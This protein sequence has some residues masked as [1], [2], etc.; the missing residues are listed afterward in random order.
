[1]GHGTVRNFSLC[2]STTW[3]SGRRRSGRG[4]GERR[5]SVRRGAKSRRARGA[6]ELGSRRRPCITQCERCAL[7]P[8]VR[9]DGINAP[10]RRVANASDRNERPIALFVVSNLLGRKHAN[11]A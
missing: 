2:T 4:I 5:G 6:Q 10:S 9:R 11:D 7:A 3:R 8:L 1:M